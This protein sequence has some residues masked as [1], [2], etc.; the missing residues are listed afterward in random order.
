MT[1]YAAMEA[2]ANAFAMELLMPHDWIVRDAANIDLC[3]DAAIAKL[4]KRYR[5]P[6]ATMAI[7]IGEVRALDGASTRHTPSDAGSTVCNKTPY[8]Q[9]RGGEG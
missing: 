9:G 3:D 4:A 8:N 7:R 2:E 5:V 1:D 6:A